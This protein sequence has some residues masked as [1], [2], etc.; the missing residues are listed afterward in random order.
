MKKTA[1]ILLTLLLV[2]GVLSGCA[3]GGQELETVRVSEVAHSVFYAPQYVA[4]S[5]DR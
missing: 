5:Q 3:A 2:L 1:A 4:M